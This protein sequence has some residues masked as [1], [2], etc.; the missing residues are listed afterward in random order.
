MKK[1]I[2]VSLLLFSI[3]CSAFAEEVESH[4]VT[5]TESNFDDVI[6]QNKF[7]LVEFYVCLSIPSDIVSK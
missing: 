1:Y 4:V 5:L 7:V 2:T 6:K 3:I